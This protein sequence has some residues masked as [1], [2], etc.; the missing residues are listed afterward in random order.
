MF[1]C[2]LSVVRC[3]FFAASVARS[4]RAGTGNRQLTT[5]LL[6]LAALP[7]AAASRPRP[8]RIPAPPP[9]AVHYR[10]DAARSGVVLSTGPRVLQASKWRSTVPSVTYSPAVFA[11]GALFMNDGA[12]HVVAFDA[13]TGTRRWTT[14]RVGSIIT[15][16]TVAGDAVYVGVDERAV[17]ALAVADG[18]QLASFPVDREVFASPAIDEGTLYVATEGGTLYAFDLGTRRERWRFAAGGPVH[19]HPA[20]V[21]GNLIVAAGPS[22]LAVD[23]FGRE[24]WRITGATPFWPPSFAVSE[25]VVYGGDAAN[26]FYAIDA[27]TGARQWTH[28]GGA[29]GDGGWSAPAVW[30]G[31]VIVGTVTNQLIAFHAPTGT[32]AWQIA[33]AGLLEPVIA[34]GV[35]YGGTA[36][37]AAGADPNATQKVYAIDAASGQI[38]SSLDVV[39][40]VKAGAAVGDGRVFLHTEARNV[41]ALE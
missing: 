21:H 1:R 13:A 23:R 2:Q 16:P 33:L 41:Y 6:L 39:G 19:G 29:A 35:I 38:I 27:D 9:A 12:G 25:G 11:G 17:I 14:A 3:R 30:N 28:E 26:S 5:V 15:A 36:S 10:G 4:A 22:L 40:Q 8:V 34:D 31:L 18:R 37:F 7:A 32:I 24:K 20:V